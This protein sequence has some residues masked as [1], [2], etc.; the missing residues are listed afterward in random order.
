[1][2]LLVTAAGS[3]GGWQ[4]KKEIEHRQFS[5]ELHEFEEIRR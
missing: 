5:N 2:C 1:M 3:R 4:A